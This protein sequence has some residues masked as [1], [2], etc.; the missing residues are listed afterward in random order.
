MTHNHKE[1][2]SYNNIMYLM[3]NKLFSKFN[4]Q[5]QNNEIIIWKK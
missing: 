2:D 5:R 1:M 3:I 4:E